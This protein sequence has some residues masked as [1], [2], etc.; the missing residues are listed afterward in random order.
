MERAKRT[1]AI[2]STVPAACPPKRVMDLLLDPSTWPNW[3]PEIVSTKGPDRVGTGDF[4]NGKASMLGFY[5][6]GWSRAT[7]V[8]ER[9]FSEDV[10]VGVGMT[11][12]YSVTATPQGTNIT[13][14]LV[15]DLP[16][17]VAG[18][19]LSL[20]LRWRLK[21]MQRVALRRLVAQSETVSTS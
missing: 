9:S 4:V 17:G 10:V 3:Q 5:V 1:F 2:Q 7:S 13:H 20:L 12:R 8:D 11:V 6:D 19:V 18:R 16:G 21:R 14:T 15:S